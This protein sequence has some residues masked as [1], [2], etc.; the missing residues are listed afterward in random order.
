MRQR[1]TDLP[2][3]RRLRGPAADPHP[4]RLAGE[5]L[6]LTEAESVGKAERLDHRLLRSEAGS[7]VAPGTGPRRGVAAL[8][9]GEDPL[10]QPGVA[11]QR[12]LQP[13]DLQQVNA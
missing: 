1:D 3:R 7:E 11:L 8:I 12:P 13:P 6:D 5:D 2:P 10:G 4:G 9:L